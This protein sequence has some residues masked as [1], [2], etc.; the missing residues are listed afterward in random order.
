MGVISVDGNDLA[1]A[2]RRA[3]RRL[4]EPRRPD[5]LESFPVGNE[6]QPRPLDGKP[7]E[8]GWYITNAM[9]AAGFRSYAQLARA[10]EISGSTL[11]RIINGGVDRPEPESLDALAVAL[12][13]DPDELR[14]RA[15]YATTG[16]PRPLHPL[17]A[18][19]DQA[20]APNSALSPE[21]RANLEQLLDRIMEAERAEIV[22][23]T[24]RRHA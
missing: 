9:S 4:P 15:G 23:R 19:I 24:R 16:G 22:R 7:T 13:L 1:A 18:E 17:A 5:A 6:S 12:N 10:A 21:R 3:I 2:P 11:S 14:A 8:L 20:L